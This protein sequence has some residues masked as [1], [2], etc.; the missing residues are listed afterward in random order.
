MLTS[1]NKESREKTRRAEKKDSGWIYCDTA[2]HSDQQQEIHKLQDLDIQVQE[3]LESN[4]MSTKDE[5][6][7]RA[8]ANTRVSINQIGRHMSKT[9]S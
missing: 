3:L 2:T 4:P 5:A 6:K 9:M 1:G 7:W 8:Q